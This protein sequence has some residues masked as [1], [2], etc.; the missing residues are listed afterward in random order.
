MSTARRILLINYEY[1]PLGGGAGTATAA[2][3]RA[4]V[5][6]GCDVVILTSRFRGQPARE[7]VNGYTIE[8]VPVLRKRMDRCTPFEM[9]TFLF[10]ASLSALRLT[11]HWK[12]EISIAFFTIPSG[13]VG[14]LLHK[15][16]GVPYI[17]SLR[18][19][20]VPGF[21]WAPVARTYHRLT[22]PVLRF[23]WRRAQHVVA[24]SNGLA[25]LA[26]QSTPELPIKVAFN[27]AE[28]PAGT[29][30]PA[31]ANGRPARLLT[32]GRLTTQKGVDVLLQALAQLRDV[33]FVLDVAGDG[34]ERAAL[35]QQA[36]ELGLQNQVRFLGW[37]TREQLPQT[38]GN[39]DVFVLASRIEGM[40]NVVLEAMAYAR[41]VICTRVSGC[42]EL[43]V[44]GETG[45]KV[46][47]DNVPQLAAALRRV[48]ADPALRT[49]MGV[50]SRARVAE[51]FTWT[52][53]ARRYLELA[54]QR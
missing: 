31:Y 10:S 36:R 24:N 52:A 46:D 26:Q 49:R 20:D 38:Y 35:E 39:A 50:A 28:L 12:P 18:G 5:D 34:P 1:P 7:K 19:G 42:E 37:L 45:L 3:A 32:M 27:G 2:I 15:L 25:A 6:L 51:E 47:I 33:P 23:I 4:M 13:P 22:G 53:T 17:V 11:K 48:L 43:I 44:D 21:E 40:P 9:L 29:V 30:P 14:W 54:E 8:R 41:P 16:R